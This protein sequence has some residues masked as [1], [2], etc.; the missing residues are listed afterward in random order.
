MAYPSVNERYLTVGGMMLRGDLYW[1]EL[2]PQIM[3]LKARYFSDEQAMLHFTDMARG[4]GPFEG[5]ALDARRE[6]WEN[7][8]A[9]IGRL[10]CAL[11]SITID[12]QRMQ[13]R[14]ATYLD[15]PYHL[16]LAWHIERLVYSLSNIERRDQLLEQGKRPLQ[17]KIIVESR[18]SADPR[19]AASYRLIFKK[20]SKRLA[21]VSAKEVQR[22]LTSNEIAFCSKKDRNIGIEI[23]DMVC[24]P[25]HWNTLFELC[26]ED[27]T[28]YKG[29][30]PFKSES[31]ELF[32]ER[33]S[34]KIPRGRDGTI[35]GHG[36]KVFPDADLLE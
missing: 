2:R 6:F 14:Y 4:R 31:V 24:N 1:T 30:H 22:R 10:D 12:K 3:A 7:L 29:S 23:A 28:E 5:L 25:L 16:I 13:T 8:L 36:L 32:W 15:D 19:L 26:F 21:T 35:R 34:G 11:I 33:V 20:G 18:G 17:G 9:V 27:L